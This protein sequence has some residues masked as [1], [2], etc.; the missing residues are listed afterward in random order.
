M[1]DQ[2]SCLLGGAKTSTWLPCQSSKVMWQEEL[3]VFGSFKLFLT[4]FLDLLKLNSPKSSCV[5]LTE[6]Q[7]SPCFPWSRLIH[8]NLIVPFSSARLTF[9][10]RPLRLRWWSQICGLA[11]PL[12]SFLSSVD[13][14]LPPPLLWLLFGLFGLRP[15]GRLRGG[16]GT[17]NHLPVYKGQIRVFAQAC[18][19]CLSN[20]ALTVCS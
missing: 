10:S 5:S 4:L 20:L 14:S 11:Q 1:V 12:T 3:H 13:S 7:V 9:I 16:K 17:I 6:S 19:Y 8:Q 2:C 18:A 15:S